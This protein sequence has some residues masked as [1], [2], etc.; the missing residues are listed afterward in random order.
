MFKKMFQ[1]AILA[2]KNA[3]VPYSGFKVGA[4]LRSENDKLY[5]GSNV[6]NAA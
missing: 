1:M 2:Q 4:C 6:E 5:I 3:Y